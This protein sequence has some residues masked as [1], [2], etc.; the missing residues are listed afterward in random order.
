LERLVN[1]IRS[2]GFASVDGRFIPGLNAISAPVLNWQEEPE[3]V[4]TLN[5][6]DS[7]I[8]KP[9]SRAVTMLREACEKISVTGRAPEAHG[10]PK[11]G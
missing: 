2:H 8:L 10:L 5:S 1:N 4:I 6:G 9:D 3:A 11:S 7:S